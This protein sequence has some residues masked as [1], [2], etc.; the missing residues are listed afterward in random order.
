VQTSVASLRVESGCGR[1][2]REIH[3]QRSATTH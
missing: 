2:R 3:V 1:M